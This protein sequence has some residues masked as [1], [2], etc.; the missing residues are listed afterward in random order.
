MF[1]VIC[2]GS[3]NSYIWF[4]NGTKKKGVAFT[5]NFGSFVT[6]TKFRISKEE[7]HV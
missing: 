2:Y 3:Q 1:S 5:T 7:I 4:S 6:A